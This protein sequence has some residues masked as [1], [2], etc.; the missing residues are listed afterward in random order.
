MQYS[1]LTFVGVQ[2]TSIKNKNVQGTGNS[3]LKNYA[4]KYRLKSR[5]FFSASVNKFNVIFKRGIIT[6][7][8]TLKFTPKLHERNGPKT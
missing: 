1:C 8:L 2:R 4:E 5:W 6:L 3:I 7:K